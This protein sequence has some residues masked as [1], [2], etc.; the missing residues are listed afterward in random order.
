MTIKYEYEWKL[1]SDVNVGQNYLTS[2]SY[3]AVNHFNKLKELLQYI[4][5]SKDLIVLQCNITVDGYEDGFSEAFVVENKL[6]ETFCDGHKVPKKYI[7]EF[8][9]N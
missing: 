6:E 7:K 5:K 9:S 3:I 1:M 4:D 8:N 2:E